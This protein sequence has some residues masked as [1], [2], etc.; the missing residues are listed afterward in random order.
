[1]SDG[2]GLSRWVHLG[3]EAGLD[4][5]SYMSWLANDEETAV[6]GVL[7]ESIPDGQRFVQAGRALMASGKPTFGYMMARSAE[8]RAAVATHTGALLGSHGLRKA[9]L[10][11]AGVV[12]VPTLRALE[13]AL[14][15]PLEGFFRSATDWRY[16]RPRAAPAR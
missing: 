5:A 1:M 13:D 12:A 9:V 11:R 16:S 7:L 2:Y 10:S 14:V 4:A 15:L 8:A 3:N 6:V